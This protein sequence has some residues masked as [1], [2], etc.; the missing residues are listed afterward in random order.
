M[1]YR[2]ARIYRGRIRAVITDLAGTTVDFGSCAPAGAFAELFARQG[3]TVTPEQARGPMGLHKRDHIAALATLPGVSAQWEQQHG[4]PCGEEDI[5]AI[6]EAFIPLQVAC[7]PKFADLIPGVLDTVKA[8]REQ[9]IAVAAT[10]GYNR[11]ML[12]TVL[13]GARSQGFEPDA[14]VCAEDVPAGRP[15]PWMNHRAMEALGVFPREGVIAIGDTLPDIE[16]GL[17]AGVWT[18]GVTATGN[19]IGRAHV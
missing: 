3:V 18:V 5:D 17:N 11:E 9:D 12:T 14:A 1:Q 19:K 13:D 6:Y 10:T 15:A 7:L 4:S 8:L 16:A 2:Y